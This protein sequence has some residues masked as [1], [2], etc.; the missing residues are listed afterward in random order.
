MVPTNNS[1]Y[2]TPISLLIVDD[3][4]VFRRFLRDIFDG[5][6]E[7]VIVG[8]AHNG[9]EALEMVLKTKPD[10]IMLD[11]EMPIMDGMMALQHLM[12][13]RPTPTIMF[14][15][16]TEEGTARCFDTMKNGAIDFICKDFIFHESHQITH[17]KLLVEK[18]KRAARVNVAAKEPIYYS[19]QVPTD[20]TGEKR[21]V[22]CEDCGQREVISLNGPEAIPTI[23]C[24][25]CGDNIDCSQFRQKH[26]RRNTFITVIGGGEGSFLN[27]LEIIPK[28]EAEMGGALIV[29]LHGRVE[30][31]NAFAEYLDSVS[32]IKVIRAREGVTVEGGHCYIASGSDHIS[33]KP[34]SAQM[35]LHRAPQV[36]PDF[37]PVD[38]LLAS[39]SAVFKKNMAGVILSGEEEDGDKGMEILVKNGG[40]PVVLDHSESYCKKMG[41][42]IAAKCLLKQTYDSFAVVKTIRRLHY[43]AKG[44]VVAEF[45]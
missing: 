45:D 3:S 43:Q 9:I 7:I 20:F 23:T 36:E 30:H 27:L 13:H 16:L 35:M 25:R 18:V 15:S 42:N 1:Q 4:L 5:C 33:L 14:S 44:D 11:V 22:F 34:Y 8:E 2:P 38:A 6:S 26:F 24:S 40:T 28:L 19:S 32:G 39:V 31:V 10:V 37:G 12:I 41:E 21:V 29:V 17:K